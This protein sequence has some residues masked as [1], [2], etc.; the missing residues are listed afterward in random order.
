MS[1][2][3]SVA[4]NLSN[5]AR[6][7]LAILSLSKAEPI[8]HLADREGVSRQFLY[9]QKQKAVEALDEAFAARDDDILFNLPATEGWL[10]QLTLA[11][12]LVCHSYYPGVRKLLRDL[13]NISI[14]VGTIHNR[15]QSAAR[16]ACAINRS[17]N[18]SAIRVGLHDEIVQGSMP[19]LAG[20]DAASTYCY[21]LADAEHRD[22]D[23]WASVLHG[24]GP[25]DRECIPIV[26]RLVPM[27]HKANTACRHHIPRAKRRVTNWAEYDAALRQRGSLTVWLCVQRRL[28]CSARVK[29]A[30][31]KIRSP[32]VWIAGWRE[33][34]TLKPIDKISRGEITSYRAVTKVNAEVASKSL[35]SEGRAYNQRAKAAWVAEI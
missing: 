10:S 16:Q 23:T 12:I 31:A 34:K 27:P 19:V 33:T 8:A 7:G 1:S 15:L 18:L 14:S 17:Q 25:G 5:D 32:V 26:V 20:V 2:S 35:K 13:F 28:A 21:L 30:G 29:L 4:A 11:L 24:T 6:K 9:R 22:A 3:P